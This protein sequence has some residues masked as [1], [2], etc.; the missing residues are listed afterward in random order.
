MQT[1]AQNI[2]SELDNPWLDIIQVFFT[3]VTM[4]MLYV[5]N[6]ICDKMAKRDDPFSTSTMFS[7]II[8]MVVVQK[9]FVEA[10][11]TAML[12]EKD[13]FN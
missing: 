10:A 5:F 12:G 6:N 4:Y 11:L 8:F 3:F 2:Q 7:L 13:F 9:Y 1:E